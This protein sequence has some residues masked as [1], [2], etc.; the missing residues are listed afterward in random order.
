M[1][2]NYKKNKNENL[3][4]KMRDSELLDLE[5]IQNYIPLYRQPYY[6]A[7]INHNDFPGAER[8]YSSTLSLPMYYGLKNKDVLIIVKLLLKVLND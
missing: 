2:L 4:K 3:F 5:N 7:N 1:E 6:S 8:Y